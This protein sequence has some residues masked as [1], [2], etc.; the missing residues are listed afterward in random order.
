MRP[1]YEKHMDDIMTGAFSSGMMEDWS[2]DDHKLLGWREDTSKK[3]K[4]VEHNPTRGPQ[5]FR[6]ERGLRS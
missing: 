1:L 5:G 3:L 6:W 2:N 4:G